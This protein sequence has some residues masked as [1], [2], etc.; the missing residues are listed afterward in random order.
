MLSN[1]KVNIMSNFKFSFLIIL[2]FISVQQLNSAAQI[3]RASSF[4][5]NGNGILTETD[6][7]EIR[8]LEQ[9][10]SINDAQPLEFEETW[11]LINVELADTL[12]LEEI[13]SRV[14]EFHPE[15]DE[16][17]NGYPQYIQ[18]HFY[19]CENK[20]GEGEP[21]KKYEL[22]IND[23]LTK[24]SISDD[25]QLFVIAVLSDTPSDEA[26][27]ARYNLNVIFKNRSYLFSQYA[28]GSVINIPNNPQ[29]TKRLIKTAWAN[30]PKS[31][32]MYFEY[33]D[34]KLEF[35]PEPPGCVM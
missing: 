28:I 1:L 3:N 13:N 27:G 21:I 6:S 14:D 25:K 26:F 8:Y 19:P 35:L 4:S 10:K 22:D 30:F 33:K 7:I 16:K 2:Y 15:W 18:I 11:K 29:I 9:R 23:I 24:E 31:P 34:G 20:D 5:K 12:F 32:F 17:R